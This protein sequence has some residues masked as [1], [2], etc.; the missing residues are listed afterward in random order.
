MKDMPKQN[1]I[2]KESII[3]FIIII[4]RNNLDFYLGIK[5]MIILSKDFRIPDSSYLQNKDI[6]TFN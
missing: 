5:R 2:E 3:L 1:S 4:I 6:L